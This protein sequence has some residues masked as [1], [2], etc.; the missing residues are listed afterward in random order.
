MKTPLF[1]SLIFG[2]S[3]EAGHLYHYHLAVQKAAQLKGWQSLAFIPKKTSIAVLPHN[4]IPCLYPDPWNQAKN[5][6]SRIRSLL[7][8]AVFIRRIF[9]SYRDRSDVL[10]FLESFE[11]QQLAALVC[12]FI[13]INRL[14][15]RFLLLHRY[16]YKKMHFKSIACRLFHWILEWKLGKDG[17][18]YVTDSELLAKSQR[19]Y[20][21]K[22]V[23]V[24]P[25]PHTTFM[26]KNYEQSFSPFFFW[27]PGS[28][29]DRSKG[30]E[31]VQNLASQLEESPDIRLVL[32]EVGKP[33]FSFHPQIIFLP[34]VLK[35]SDY[36]KWMHRTQIVLLP[37]SP[38][39]YSQRTSGIF[40][41][42]VC[43]GAIPI[44]SK[45]TWMEYELEKYAL[46]QL[47]FDWKEKRLL[48]LIMKAA[49]DTEIRNKLDLMRSGYQR[50]HS[51]EGFAEVLQ[52]VSTK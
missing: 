27:W 34:S 36:Y 18:K 48:E 33:V 31:V 13:S 7:I 9:R 25:I 28:C 39:E 46:S 52:R 24:V 22:E 3:S 10:L 29:V 2:L 44:V 30:L 35:T 16:S 4:W 40:I 20:F 38:E 1:C 23:A 15:F 14:K 50:F 17:V 43:A 47:A 11:L 49:Q 19:M 32:S 21:R 51:E 42:A 8:N 26:G 6:F 12:A 41:E 45:G 5:L 37:Y